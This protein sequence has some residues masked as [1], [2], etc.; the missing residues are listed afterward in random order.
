[1]LGGGIIPNSLSIEKEV[2]NILSDKNNKYIAL[3]Q[4]LIFLSVFSCFTYQWVARVIIVA[5][6]LTFM[7]LPGIRKIVFSKKS[8]FVVLAFSV[9]GWIVSLCYVNING[10]VA[11]PMFFAIMYFCIVVRDIM[12]R[13]F[14]EKML[15][16]M[17]AGGCFASF[18]AAI[19]K[20]LHIPNYSIRVQAGF[21]NPNFLG[22]ALMI[23]V[24]VC[25]YK[26]ANDAKKPIVYFVIA[27]INAGGILL[28]GSMSLWVVMAIG[29][30]ILF[31]MN[32]NTR[33]L[34]ALLSAMAIV[35][36]AL[37][38]VPQIFTRLDEVSLTTQNRLDIWAFTIENI[39]TAPI[40]GRGF[41]AYKHLYGQMIATRPE[42]IQVSLAHNLVLDSLL[43][44]GIVGS[45][46]IWSYIIL[47]FKDLI[48]C[49]KKLKANGQSRTLNSFIIAVCIAIL[50]Y[51]IIDTTFVWVQS[52][53]PLLMILSGLG[54]DE[55]KLK[56]I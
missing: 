53:L 13:A 27:V 39:K 40:F 43:C 10:I 18:V 14:F 44:H 51:G 9:L 3:A 49:R 23:A 36:L 7:F 22:A 26:V 37:F 30:I 41:Y 25:I 4:K 48:S 12:T 33:M 28:C 46:V 5:T 50:L 2:S 24:F 6:V 8:S 38:L 11:Y 54:A 35:I 34:I 29:S 21:P 55:N 45:G 15:D 16:V 32:K 31:V 42:L 1:M 20:I 47:Y 52:G 17:C 56:S 19:E